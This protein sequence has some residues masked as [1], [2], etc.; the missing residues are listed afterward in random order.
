MSVTGI[1]QVLGLYFMETGDIN[2]C[3]TGLLA[4]LEQRGLMI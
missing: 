1:G 2:P 3:T 4:G